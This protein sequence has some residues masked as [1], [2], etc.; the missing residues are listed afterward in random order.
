MVLY[1]GGRRPRDLYMDGWVQERLAELPQLRYIPVVSDAWL[2]GARIVA[3]IPPGSAA[4]IRNWTPAQQREM[5]GLLGQGDGD[6]AW[7]TATNGS[8]LMAPIVRSTR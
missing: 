2:F 8:I 3:Q 6:V 1:W 4:R 7:M 5:L